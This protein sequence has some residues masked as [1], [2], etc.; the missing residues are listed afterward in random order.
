MGEEMLSVDK[1]KLLSQEQ[2]AVR[3]RYWQGLLGLAHWSIDVRIVRGA[4]IGDNMGQTDYSTVSEAAVVRLKDSVDYHG[5]F[6]CDHE[7]TLVHELLHLVLDKTATDGD[8]YE[9]VLDRV[10]RVLVSL[11]RQKDRGR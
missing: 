2:L 1:S 11:D 9:Q 5:F 7:E 8:A 3:C 4:D 10:A 6:P